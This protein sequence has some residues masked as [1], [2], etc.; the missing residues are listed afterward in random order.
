MKG[1]QAPCPSK[2]WCSRQVEMHR[3]SP[4]QRNSA[5]FGKATSARSEGEV[6]SRCVEIFRGFKMVALYAGV[7]AGDVAVVE[8]VCEDG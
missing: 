5:S 1:C 4:I 7:G 8:D 2:A 3:S 6:G